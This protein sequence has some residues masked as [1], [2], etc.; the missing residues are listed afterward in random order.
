MKLDD[1]RQRMRAFRGIG[2][3]GTG[4]RWIEEVDQQVAVLEAH[5]DEDA[6]CAVFEDQG[7]DGLVVSTRQAKELPGACTKLSLTIGCRCLVATWGWI[8]QPEYPCR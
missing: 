6:L 2:I 4:W 7:S 5:H 1:V 3:R 8:R